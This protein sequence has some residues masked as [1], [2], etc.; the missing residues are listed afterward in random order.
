MGEE[1]MK[2]AKQEPVYLMIIEETETKEKKLITKDMAKILKA[3]VNE[4]K[5]IFI[6]YLL[7]GKLSICKNIHLP[8]METKEGATP[9]FWPIYKILPWN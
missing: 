9:K 3:V 1:L 8:E 7:A 6:D 5:D 2:I 4:F